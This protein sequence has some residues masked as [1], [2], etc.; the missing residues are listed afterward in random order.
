[1]TQFHVRDPALA[2]ERV[3]PGDGNLEKR[4]DLSRGED[5]PR[6]IR[7]RRSECFDG[8]S[9]A[10]QH[11]SREL[12]VR[13]EALEKGVGVGVPRKRLDQL[14]RSQQ[15]SLGERGPPDPSGP[16]GL[17]GVGSVSRPR[18]LAHVDRHFS[19]A[20]GCRRAASS[21]RASTDALHART[22]ATR[23]AAPTWGPP[24]NGTSTRSA[25]SPFGWS[26]A[27]GAASSSARTAP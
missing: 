1:M 25:G 16:A 13:C 17:L 4:G 27:R 24:S 19:P 23:A 12:H 6:R 18:C 3:H 9:P 10:V 22:R 11:H 2:G 7:G 20:R 5:R 21:T 8:I 15:C 14:A 26:T